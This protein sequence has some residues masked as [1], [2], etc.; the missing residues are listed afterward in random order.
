[1]N[2]GRGESSDLR[3]SSQRVMV[4]VLVISC[5]YGLWLLLL[6]PVIVWRHQAPIIGSKTPVLEL[7]FMHKLHPQSR[8]SS[9]QTQHS[10]GSAVR[11]RVMLSTRSSKPPEVGQTPHFDEQP[12]PAP[13]DEA[14]TTAVPLPPANDG[15]NNDGGF[16]ER[17]HND[18]RSHSV[19]GVPGSDTTYAAGIHLVDPMNQGIGAIMRTT[20]RA[21]GI[22]SSHCVDVDVWRHLTP[23]ELSARHVSPDDVD[24][25][26]EKY[27]CN[28]PPGL[29]F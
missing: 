13:S 1:M 15:S 28:D 6:R 20:Q 7:R 29:H 5:H 24:R 10:I 11:S 22:T 9:L 23:Q 12:P 26:D 27:R 18:Q 2:R 3:T 19:H 14:L 25:V 17:L 8:H 21:F 16:L 4:L